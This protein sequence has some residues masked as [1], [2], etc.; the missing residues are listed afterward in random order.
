LTSQ[1]TDA[2]A[3]N[4]ATIVVQYAAA[5]RMIKKR[6]CAEARWVCASSARSCA[7]AWMPFF[8]AALGE[9]SLSVARSVLCAW[10]AA[11]FEDAYAE[12]RRVCTR[13]SPRATSDALARAR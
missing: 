11:P 7:L 4:A 1:W 10:G 13:R 9:R 6:A 12:T 8:A 2:T 5:S 3:A